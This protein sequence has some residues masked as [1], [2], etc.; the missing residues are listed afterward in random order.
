MDNYETAKLLISA[1]TEAISTKDIPKLLPSVDITNKQL[2]Q[3]QLRLLV[4]QEFLQSKHKVY[5][6]DLDDRQFS[7]LLKLTPKAYK[8]TYK[9]TIVKYL[10]VSNENS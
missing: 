3:Q 6:Q 8:D 1:Y 7:V 4:L 5:F 2:V 10:E 9:S